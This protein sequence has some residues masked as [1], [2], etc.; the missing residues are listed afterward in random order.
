MYNLLNQYD[1]VTVADFYDCIGESKEFTDESYGWVSLEGT[2]VSSTRGGFFL[3][4]PPT[5]L[6][7]HR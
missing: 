5:E 7:N 6:L 1:A 4:L 2:R 3:D